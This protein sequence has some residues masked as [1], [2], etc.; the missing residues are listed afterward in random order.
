MNLSKFPPK[1]N[2]TNPQI[3][4]LQP[5]SG[6][7]M[8]PCS[9]FNRREAGHQ[10]RATAQGRAVPWTGPGVPAA[11]W[12]STVPPSAVRPH[13]RTCPNNLQSPLPH[14]ISLASW[15]SQLQ[16]EGEVLW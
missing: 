14:T 16:G 9:R 10:Q 7:R 12:Q 8:F 2:K 13:W 11:C 3:S 1:V 5:L 4:K 15:L 6:G